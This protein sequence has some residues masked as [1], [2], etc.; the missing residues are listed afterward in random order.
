MNPF[1]PRDAAADAKGPPRPGQEGVPKVAAVVPEPVGRVR[2]SLMS[3]LKQKL[4]GSSPLAKALRAPDAQAQDP[5]ADAIAALREIRGQLRKVRPL[6]AWVV[7]NLRVIDQLEGTLKRGGEELPREWAH[8]CWPAPPYGN[9]QSCLV[10]RP[11]E[12]GSI[13]SKSPWGGD[14]PALKRINDALLRLR[15]LPQHP[16][17]VVSVEQYRSDIKGILLRLQSHT[18][19]PYSIGV[20]SGERIKLKDGGASRGSLQSQKCLWHLQEALKQALAG[21]DCYGHFLM[22]TL[23]APVESIQAVAV[24]LDARVY[25]SSNSR[26]A[27]TVGSLWKDIVGLIRNWR[28]GVDRDSKLPR[29]GPMILAGAEGE[30]AAVQIDKL[31]RDAP[32]GEAG[33]GAEE[34]V[35]GVAQWELELLPPEREAALNAPGGFG[36][37]PAGG[38]GPDEADG[39]GGAG[40]GGGGGADAERGAERRQ[41]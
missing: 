18:D 3:R 36:W 1:S 11:D 38:A 5:A 29:P 30:L 8:L 31:L 14:H 9:F 21:Q 4:V 37:D 39:Y 10:G 25:A 16:A 24:E 28:Q 33:D 17:A 22:F 34:N 20:K 19:S 7:A 41:A 23:G 13:D 6:E 26:H 2:T 15:V 40:G 32:E 35:D 27:K 12:F